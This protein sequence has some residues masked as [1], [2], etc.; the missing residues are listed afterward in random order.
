MLWQIGFDSPGVHV[1][2]EKCPAQLSNSRTN[3]DTSTTKD[4]SQQVTCSVV[5]VDKL[6]LGLATWYS[7]GHALGVHCGQEMLVESGKQIS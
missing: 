1:S 3:L 4:E 6:N 7:L 5:G 2:F